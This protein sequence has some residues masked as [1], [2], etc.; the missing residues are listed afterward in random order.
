MHR[1]GKFGIIVTVA[2]LLALLVPGVALGAQPTSEREEFTETFDDE[3]LTDVCGVPVTTTVNGTIISRAFED[4]TTGLTEW[5]TL[6]VGFT[7]TSDFG[8][9]RFRDVGADVTIVQP[10][11]TTVL[12]IIGQLPFDFTGIIKVDLEEDELILQSG[13]DRGAKQLDKACAALTP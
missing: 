2:A 5:T 8:T 12:S 13:G 11:G 9:F 6:N 4:A 1:I 10:D 3:F 7:A